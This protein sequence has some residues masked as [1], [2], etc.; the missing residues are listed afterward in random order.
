MA[1]SCIRHPAVTYFFLHCCRERDRHRLPL[2]ATMRILI[3]DDEPLARSRL[4]QILGR[5]L[6]H[7]VVA[8]CAGV[9]DARAAIDAYR[10]DAV[11]LDVELAGENGLTFAAELEEQSYPVVI[12]TAYDHYAAQA[13]DVSPVDF[14]V[15]PPEVARCRRAAARL[16][17]VMDARHRKHG[18]DRYLDRL[19]V[20]NGDRI[21]HVRM[22]DVDA[23]AALGN[24]V[25]VYAG[26]HTHVV[27]ASLSAL[28]SRLDPSVFVRTHRSWIVNLTRVRE[29]IA[30]SHGDYQV[31]MEKGATAPLSRSY[32]HRLDL[33][34]LF[35][36]AS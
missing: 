11:F 20:R 3:V 24:Y 13:F 31:I 33:F 27:R 18:S 14:V 16:E 22:Q 17:R 6:G 25:K 36:P 32:R 2:L 21:V 19:F 12:V 5:E 28:E 34:S 15:K 7:D 9:R 26:E 23:V 8:A 1:V 29:L 4:E 10:P 30:V 35:A